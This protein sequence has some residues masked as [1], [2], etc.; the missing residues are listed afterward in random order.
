MVMIA[1]AC[2]EAAYHLGGNDVVLCLGFA[3]GFK[4]RN[5]RGC[6]L[7]CCQDYGSLRAVSLRLNAFAYHTQQGTSEC[8]L[9]QTP[10]V[11]GDPGAWLL[12]DEGWLQMDGPT[13]PGDTICRNRA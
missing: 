11:H 4:E 3:A 1:G 2:G 12:K 10:R 6:S 8:P 9:H 7:S 13:S 5:S